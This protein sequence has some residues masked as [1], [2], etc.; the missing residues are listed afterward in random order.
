[1]K[2]TN[3]KTTVHPVVRSI[4]LEMDEQ[5]SILLRRLNA[6]ESKKERLSVKGLVERVERLEVENAT[7]RKMRLDGKRQEF[8][9]AEMDAI[10][11]IIRTFAHFE[12]DDE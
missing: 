7:L 10:R 3:K 9:G 8:S 5:N 12:N 4:R 1:M 2:T 11:R 6:L